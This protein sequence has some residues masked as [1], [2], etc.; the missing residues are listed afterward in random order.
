MRVFVTGATG[1]IGRAL[2]PRLQRDGHTVIVWTRSAARARARLGADV[3]IVTGPLGGPAAIGA[4]QGCE[5][6]VNLAGEPILGQRWSRTRRAQLESSRVQLTEQLVDAMAAAGVRRTVLVSGSAVGYYGDRGDEILS[7]SSPHGN[8]YLAELC[9]RWEWAARKAENLGARVVLLRTGV[10]FGREGG[11]LAQMLPPF[12][13]GVGG[14]IGS[15]RQYVPW[16][17]LH[18]LVSVIATALTDARYWGPVNGVAPEPVTARDVAYAIG[19]ALHRPAALPVPAVALR[20]IFGEA[21]VVLLASQRV[22]PRELTA[23]G[24]DWEFPSLGAAL[25]DILDDRAVSIVHRG[26]SDGRYELRVKAIVNAPLDRTFAFFSKADNL[27][28]LT[29]ASMKFAIEGAAPA[30]ATGTVIDY[31]I[32]IGPM[33]LS[34][35]T[36]IAEWEPGRSFVDV[37]DKGPY[38]LWRHRHAFEDDGGRTVMEDRVLYTPPLGPLGRIANRLFIA[39]ELRRIFQYRRDII[40]LRFG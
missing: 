36:R 23:C 8:D 1:F 7:E 10:V 30:M 32:A 40:R 25:D 4:L 14:P 20:T 6:V 22:E 24:F 3:E 15:G 39:P 9:I 16:I 34:W 11:A 17:H 18:D 31:R 13:L 27:G 29:P 5:G 2:V 19:G 33:P 21:A 37:Q 12:R 38:T 28:L 26:A 35:R